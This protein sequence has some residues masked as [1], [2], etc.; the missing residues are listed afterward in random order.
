MAAVSAAV[1]AVLTPQMWLSAERLVPVAG[2]F[3][4][5]GT[6]AVAKSGTVVG[7]LASDPVFL[8]LAGVSPGPEALPAVSAILGRQVTVGAGS[9]E[10]WVTVRDRDRERARALVRAV[11]EATAAAEREDRRSDLA[12]R[13]EDFER[14]QSERRARIASLVAAAPPAGDVV[15]VEVHRARVRE[16]AARLAHVEEDLAE[17]RLRQNEPPL[18]WEVAEAPGGIEESLLPRRLGPAMVAAIV[19]P[20]LLV[21]VV[22]LMT[23]RPRQT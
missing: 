22:M 12:C 23:G 9:D 17:C 6:V 18:P 15:A 11:V 3:D 2:A 7:A 5:K 19:A 1:V 14:E 4:A 13:V 20:L 10:V 8:A 21:A 16:S